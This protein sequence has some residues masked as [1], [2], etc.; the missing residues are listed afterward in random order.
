M[1]K[2]PATGHSRLKTPLAATRP[3]PVFV[4]QREGKVRLRTLTPAEVTP[5]IAEWLSDPAVMEGVNAPKTA[6]GLEAFRA[7]VAS[8]DQIRRNLMAIRLAPDDRPIG[9]AMMEVDLRHAIGSIH[10]LI[11]DADNRG[12]GI[13]IA[14]AIL[15]IRNF[16]LDRKLEKLSIAPLER[17]EKVIAICESYGLRL[18]G[19]LR[20]HRIDGRTGERLDQRYYGLT[21]E[22]Y[23]KLRERA[24]AA[25]ATRP[26]AQNR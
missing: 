3:K 8:F 15:M 16:F 12:Q 18:E 13:G 23:M 11:G 20:S 7:Y 2:M 25:Q 19:I 17:N 14:A 22:E 1:P 4:D 5:E 21:R 10:M 26:E 24:L 6:M 9:I